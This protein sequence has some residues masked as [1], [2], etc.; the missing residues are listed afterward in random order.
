MMKGYGKMSVAQ[1]ALRT[2]PFAGK[3][4]TEVHGD[5]ASM[6]YVANLL[7]E[8]K[9]QELKD[10]MKQAG[11]VEFCKILTDDGTDFGWSRGIA[12]VKYA[13][14]AEAELA[15]AT[16]AQTELEGRKIWVDRWTSGKTAK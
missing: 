12:C 6:V 15:I 13:T 7:F 5:P 16:L 8:T 9:W 10:H 2:S 1:S 14:A 3:G 4:K 11:T